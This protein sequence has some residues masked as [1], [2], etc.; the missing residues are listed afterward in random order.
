MDSGAF[1]PVPANWVHIRYSHV[2]E[3]QRALMRD[4]FQARIR[5]RLAPL[6]RQ[7]TCTT[8]APQLNNSLIIGVKPLDPRQ[9]AAVSGTLSVLRACMCAV[10]G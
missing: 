5:S 6:A 8:A 3:A 7:L 9:R 2:D 1:A 4:G 10:V